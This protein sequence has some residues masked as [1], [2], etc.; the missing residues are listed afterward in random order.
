MPSEVSQT[1]KTNT[2]QFHLHM[3]SKKQDKTETDSD[4][5]SKLV[6]ARGAGCGKLG[7]T[8]EG[9]K[10][11]KL[12]VIKQI[13]HEDVRYSIGN[14]VNNIVITLYGDRWLLDLLL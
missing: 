1:E 4:T 7:E 5:E 3:E 2:I 13:S 8:G 12:P 11:Y 10:K 14:T 6:A 9:I